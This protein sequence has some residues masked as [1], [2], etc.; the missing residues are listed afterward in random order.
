MGWI[1][2]LMASGEAQSVDPWDETVINGAPYHP[3]KPFRGRAEN[4]A[5][6]ADS[7]DALDAQDAEEIKRRQV[8]LAV[9]Y[10]TAVR[11]R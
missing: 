2:R 11:A 5:G 6:P 1:S 10:V 8:S 4:S 9:R 3:Q 7:L